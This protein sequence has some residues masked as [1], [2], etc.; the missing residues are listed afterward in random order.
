MD[1]IPLSELDQR[2]YNPTKKFEQHT[3]GLIQI[4]TKNGLHNLI[5]FKNPFF[6]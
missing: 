4:N 5:S 3:E 2:C 6:F 1:T